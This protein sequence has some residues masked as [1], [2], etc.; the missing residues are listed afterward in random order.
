[1]SVEQDETGF[2]KTGLIM[3]EGEGHRLR[4]DSRE[5]YYRKTVPLIEESNRYILTYIVLS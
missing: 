3:D 1:M 2:M 4:Q 5:I